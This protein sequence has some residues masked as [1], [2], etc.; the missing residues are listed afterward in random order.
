VEM[1]KKEFHSWFPVPG[2]FELGYDPVVFEEVDDGN[3]E[4]A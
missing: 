4:V 1:I 2:E 3:K